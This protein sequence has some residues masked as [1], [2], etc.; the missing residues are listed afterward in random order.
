[1]VDV[2]ALVQQM[3]DNLSAIHETLSGI[4]TE[5][6]DA[7]LTELEQKRDSLLDELRSIFDK[8][9]EEVSAKRQVELDE[10]KE[11]RRIEDEEREARRKQEDDDLQSKIDA[12]DLERHEK[13]DGDIKLIDEDTDK[14]MDEVEQ[15]AKQLIDGARQKLSELEERRK[16]IN[17]L[18]DE[19]LATPLPEVP[20][21]KRTR[22]EKSSEDA[23]GNEQQVVEA[24]EEAAQEPAEAAAGD[25]EQP[26]AE[27][28]D[29]PEEPAA[30]VNGEDGE[31]PAEAGEEATPATEE[32]NGD[33]GDAEEKTTDVS[34]IVV[35]TPA[36][37]TDGEPAS[38]PDPPCTEEQPLDNSDKAHEAETPSPS[39]PAAMPPVGAEEEGDATAGD[40]IQQQAGPEQT[41]SVEAELP[42]EDAASDVGVEHEAGDLANSGMELV[43]SIPTTDSGIGLDPEVEAGKSRPASP[44]GSEPRE[45]SND[46][47]A[48]GTHEGLAHDANPLG[49]DA[50]KTNEDLT[51]SQPDPMSSRDE[52][53]MSSDPVT[54]SATGDGT[55]ENLAED[56]VPSS[57]EE[58]PVAGDLA[59]DLSREIDGSSTEDSQPQMSTSEP[60][61]TDMGNDHGGPQHGAEDISMDA[62]TLS[63]VQPDHK[64]ES[65]KDDVRSDSPQPGVEDLGSATPEEP[66]TIHQEGPVESQPVDQAESSAAVGDVQGTAS[67]EEPGTT[68]A[69]LG[70]HSDESTTPVQDGQQLDAEACKSSTNDT[71][72]NSDVDVADELPEVGQMTEEGDLSDATTSSHEQTLQKEQPVTPAE[73]FSSPVEIG[74]D[75][76]SEHE[77][78]V[79]T[80]APEPA[81]PVDVLS[82]IVDDLLSDQQTSSLPQDEHD[83]GELPHQISDDVGSTSEQASK[84]LGAGECTDGAI[85]TTNTL[86]EKEDL[87][88]MVTSNDELH[89]ESEELSIINEEGASINDCERSSFLDQNATKSGN[90]PVEDGSIVESKDLDQQ[91]H[92]PEQV[93]EP[94][95]DFVGSETSMP[96]PES[97]SNHQNTANHVMDADVSSDSIKGAAG[98]SPGS[99]VGNEDA[100]ELAG[101]SQTPVDQPQEELEPDRSLQGSLADEQVGTIPLFR[102]NVDIPLLSNT[103]SDEH[104]G[105]ERFRESQGDSPSNEEQQPT[106]EVGAERGMEYQEEAYTYPAEERSSV[107]SADGT[108][109]YDLSDLGWLFAAS[110]FY[111]DESVEDIQ[112]SLSDYMAGDVSR[113]VSVDTPVRTIPQF[114]PPVDNVTYEDYDETFDDDESASSHFSDEEDSGIIDSSLPE[115]R[116]SREYH[117]QP[118]KAGQYDGTGWGE[119]DVSY[120]YTDDSTN[121]LHT[122]AT[123][124]Q[125]PTPTQ[126]RFDFA[127]SFGIRMVHDAEPR[128]ATDPEDSVKTPNLAPVTYSNAPEVSPLV[129]RGARPMTPNSGGLATSRRTLSR[130]PETPTRPTERAMA[131]EPVPEPEL[132]PAMFVPRDVTHVP[133]HARADSVP[134]SIRSR[135]TLSSGPSSPVHS[136]LPVDKHEPKIRDS[137]HGPVGSL[138]HSR[139]NTQATDR[140]SGEEFDPFRYDSAKPSPY[141]INSP[142]RSVQIHQPFTETKPLSE[143]N[144]NSIAGSPMFQKLRNMFE[145]P[146]GSGSSSSSSSPTKSRPVSNIFIPTGR[147]RSSSQLRESFVP[148]DPG[149]TPRHGSF[150]NENEDDFDERSSLLEHSAGVTTLGVEGG[151]IDIDL[152]V[153]QDSGSHSRP[154]QPPPSTPPVCCICSTRTSQRCGKCGVYYCSHDCQKEDLPYHKGVCNEL[155]LL[156]SIRHPKDHVRCLRFPKGSLQPRWC[157][158][159]CSND[160]RMDKIVLPIFADGYQHLNDGEFLDKLITDVTSP[161]ITDDVT[162]PG[163]TTLM[164]VTP[165]P[166]GGP[167][168]G[169]AAFNGRSADLNVG[170]ASLGRPGHLYPWTADAYLVVYQVKR[171]KDGNARVQYQDVKMEHHRPVLNFLLTNPFNP[172]IV[173][174]VRDKRYRIPAI[175][176]NSV[177]DRL[178][179]GLAVMDVVEVPVDLFSGYQWPSALAFMVG[180]PWVC[181]LTAAHCEIL[182]TVDPKESDKLILRNPEA[183]L[184]AC[185]YKDPTGKGE[186]LPVIRSLEDI[187]FQKTPG[188]IMVI[189]MDG[190][191]IYE[192]HIK[193]FN[194][195]MGRKLRIYEGGQASIGAGWLGRKDF[196]AHWEKY[197]RRKQLSLPSPYEVFP[198]NIGL[199][200][201]EIDI[202][203]AR[204]LTLQEPDDFPSDTPS[205]TSGGSGEAGPVDQDLTLYGS[206]KGAEE[207][208]GRPVVS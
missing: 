8:E 129:L 65:V 73:E 156:S 189:H 88:A 1:M 140:S 205:E 25:A 197:K 141:D 5:S 100:D 136:A 104:W 147:E 208:I 119:S 99:L 110:S 135:S 29:V 162:T 37:A 54:Q 206:S 82:D 192:D 200:D 180:L 111:A 157:F 19:Q 62:T 199:R 14:Q 144:R 167:T 185:V 155:S 91:L 108:E 149:H 191:V 16:E 98:S 84:D 146:I 102:A 123:P 165:R 27:A 2:S 40:G 94:T 21:R 13:L 196:I 131:P 195:F 175:K 115:Q 109:H 143:T 153:R 59:N 148:L 74:V 61:E 201:Q 194:E 130:D 114:Q 18:I 127:N 198:G 26:P 39:D 48:E 9:Q 56:T 12:E 90:D 86:G 168:A 204:Y 128:G 69:E 186:Y 83:D 202:W 179:H 63:A 106:E 117:R 134:Y 207:T 36:D 163:V 139:T 150:R 17:R 124:F 32:P 169:A 137:W 30:E 35:E 38:M 122:A 126:G 177:G 190:K 166:F 178:S 23:D 138:G 81:E 112:Y 57:G 31:K 152:R 52:Q 97:P 10:I 85:E 164:L 183:I 184:L 66:S 72:L 42:K 49:P 113:S 50:D 15:A 182:Q 20:T 105:S 78:S 116:A 118:P 120:E 3:H 64:E 159:K 133:W 158:V 103:L 44:S 107:V 203:H 75:Q 33:A 6:H 45:P 172:C 53:P 170:I 7:Q 89:V 43:L 77:G 55:S 121:E 46:G 161:E 4:T 58:V 93:R 101:R 151:S 34:E 68:T 67:T 188:T 125:Q 76:Q 171:D 11:K 47:A 132:D 95:P 173:P 187:Q 28:G 60:V 193:A 79:H 154:P 142:R 87:P 24:T 80:E 145:A 181:R 51:S 96:M 70:T 176:I 71:S 160:E 22:G 174:D 41:S 92:T